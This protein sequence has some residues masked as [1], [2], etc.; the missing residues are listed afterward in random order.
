[1]LNASS[2]CSNGEC[3]FTLK[4]VVSSKALY[5]ERKVV[6]SFRTGA[7]IAINQE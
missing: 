4:Y 6:R 5:S 2:Q 1:L 3:V 7:M